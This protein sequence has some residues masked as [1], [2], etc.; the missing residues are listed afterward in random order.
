MAPQHLRLDLYFFGTRTAASHDAECPEIGPI[1]AERAEPPQQH[2]TTLW[3][4]EARLLGE[5]GLTKNF[6]LQA[7]V[8][9]RL[10]STTTLFTDLAGTP[11]T[12]DY[13]NIHHR[14]EVLLGLGDL[15]LL[16]HGALS[17]GDFRFG[18]RAGLS[19]PT[20]RVS[21]NPYVL[22]DAGLPHQH[23]QF[24]TGTF[25]P[26]LGFDLART[27]GPV[28]VAAFAQTQLPLYQGPRGLQAGVRLGGGLVASSSLGLGGPVFRLSTSVFQE[29]AERW[30]GHV[31]HEDGNQGRTDFYV[32][33]GLTWAFARDWSLSA[34]VR[35]R[36]WG[37]TV[38]AQ[39]SMP[40]VLELSI[41]R[42]FHFEDGKHE[43]D[44]H[45]EPASS[46]GMDVE[47]VVR[48]GELAQLVA[49]PGKW[50][51]FDFWA[52]WC[53][54]CKVLDRELRELGP[55]V[56][57]RRVNIVD[58]DSPIATRELPGV[59]VLPR[60]RLV[61]PSGAVV[62]EA[63]GKVDRLLDAVRE[64]LKVS[65]TCPMHPEERSAAPGACSVCGMPLKQ[66]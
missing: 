13:Q 58:F 56:A 55:S 33:P 34:D 49:A 35:I 6:A 25:D 17:L 29:F 14:N 50:T 10:I 9:V 39:L 16:L 11:L 61:D 42:L 47:D 38:N 7:V 1:C 2:H 44:E 54:A 40:V 12:L 20:G 53:E 28:T 37:Q 46:A 4:T 57:I 21:A 22:G 43:D 41:G 18:G 5:Y 60:I 52:P 8:P 26:I 31:P 64:K 3:L 65:Y 48:N 19:F 63:S 45:E 27:F 51:V 32:G 15:Q 24:G 66:R 59:S 62:F 30:D 36:A 23:I